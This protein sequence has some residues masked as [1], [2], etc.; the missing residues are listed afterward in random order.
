MKT[1]QLTGLALKL[2]VALGY[3]YSDLRKNPHRFCDYLIMTPPGGGAVEFS[4][5]EFEDPWE[6]MLKYQIEVMQ[7]GSRSWRATCKNEASVEFG[8]TPEIAAKRAF[9][10]A[11][12]GSEFEIP[13]LLE[14]QDDPT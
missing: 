10:A 11:L 2:A 3:G 5:I 8:P 9:V 4:L 13:E 1:S 6:F 7:M 14:N 12:V